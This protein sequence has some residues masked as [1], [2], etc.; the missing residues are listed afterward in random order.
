MSEEPT[1]PLEQTKLE[2][3]VTWVMERCPK[4]NSLSI[5]E[6][7]AQAVAIMMSFGPGVKQ[8]L[9]EMELAKISLMGIIAMHCR[10][11]DEVKFQEIDPEAYLQVS[12]YYLDPDDTGDK[13]K[14]LLLKLS[15][16]TYDPFEP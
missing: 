1:K 3:D 14:A 10:Q 13:Y 15:N 2:Q 7:T 5:L 4:L 12:N 8:F 9:D 6:P 16:I 11:L